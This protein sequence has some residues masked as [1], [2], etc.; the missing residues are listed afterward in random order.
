VGIRI[1][2]P[3]A[4]LLLLVTSTTMADSIDVQIRDS[5]SSDGYFV[6]GTSSSRL[7]ATATGGSFHSIY[8]GTFNLEANYGVGW[9]PLNTYCLQPTLGIRFGTY[10]YDTTGRT[11]TYTS[12]DDYAPITDDESD[13]LG[14]LWANAFDD[15][16]TGRKTAA[17]FQAIVWETAVDDSFNLT[18]GDFRVNGS[19][20]FSSN[21]LAIADDWVSNIDADI[22]TDRVSLAALTNDCSQDFLVPSVVPTTT[23]TVPTPTAWALGSVTLVFL[24]VRRRA[25]SRARRA[26]DSPC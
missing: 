10:P 26:L 11:Y 5:A 3:I 24:A 17:A 2:V 8:T 6:P 23:S 22:W 12:M 14:V 21:V 1:M 15:A 13:F 16:M 20:T 4:L 25:T 7:Q 9:G 19:S 18:G